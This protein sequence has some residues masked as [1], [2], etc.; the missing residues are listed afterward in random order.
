MYN[1]IFTLLDTMISSSSSSSSSS[2]PSHPHHDLSLSSSSSHHFHLQSYGNYQPQY[3]GS[4][5][6]LDVLSIVAIVLGTFVTFLSIRF[7]HS[8]LGIANCFMGWGTSYYL[9]SRYLPDLST[10]TVMWASALCGLGYLLI[11]IIIP[12]G[13]ALAGAGAGCVIWWIIFATWPTLWSSPDDLKWSYTILAAT[14][15]G[16]ML[17]SLGMKELGII[18]STPF[19]GS[20][21][22]VQG[23]NHWYSANLQALYVLDRNFLDSCQPQNNCYYYIGIGIGGGVLLGWIVQAAL[24][25]TVEYLDTAGGEYYE[26][27][28]KTR[29]HRF[30]GGG[31]F[32]RPRRTYLGSRFGRRKAVAGGAVAGPAAGTNYEETVVDNRGS[33][34]SAPAQYGGAGYGYGT[35]RSQYGAAADYPTMDLNNQQYNRY[36]K[37]SYYA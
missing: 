23:L 11:S 36:N 14:G 27:G 18:F 22:I 19:I 32:G 7:P 3:D 29:L 24:L 16:M 25:R 2:I 4:N 28:R 35:P 15:G 17:L 30:T 8:H 37:P 26:E 5:T 1:N 20:F 13:I 31:L 12:I 34:T 33:Y 21:M 10:V 9:I 6:T